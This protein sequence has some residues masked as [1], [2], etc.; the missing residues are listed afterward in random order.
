MS[1]HSQIDAPVPRL[2]KPNLKPA[3]ER[4]SRE[5]RERGKIGEERKFTRRENE[6]D[7]L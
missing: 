2:L 3:K 5:E 4:K 7:Y 6:L 1:F